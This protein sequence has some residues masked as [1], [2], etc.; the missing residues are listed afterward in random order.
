ML[1]QEH[2]SHL[3]AEAR[4]AYQQGNLARAEDLCRQILAVQRAHPDALNL[5]GAIAQQVGRTDVAIAC[6]RHAVQSDPTNAH[7]HN[8][9]G[10][11][12]THAE[13]LLE[14]VESYRKAIRL[15]PDFAEAHNNLTYALY[16]LGR[17]D[18][19]RASGEQALRLR[20]SFPEANNHL[21]LALM[22]LDR[23]GEAAEQFQTALRLQPRLPAVQR[24]LANAMRALG[25]H[26]DAMYHFQ[27]ALQLDPN[28]AEV[29]CDLGD[30][31]KEQGRFDEAV[32]HFRQALRSK[33]DYALAYWNLSEFA[34]QGLSRLTPEELAQIQSL[35][36]SDRLP[37]LS[38]SVLH[39]TLGN[40]F[41]KQ[42]PWDQA[43]PHFRQGNA[44]RKQLLEQMGQGFDVA[45]HRT[46]IDRTIATF[47]EEFFRQEPPGGSDSEL[48]VFVV[49]MPRS[50]TSLVEQILASHSKAAGAGELWDLPN[51]VANLQRQNKRGVEYPASLGSMK[52]AELGKLAAP[53][54][55][56]L[57]RTDDK[58][59]RVVDKMPQNFLHL[60]LIA[61]LF[62]KAR[63][64]HC[65]R[66]PFDVC[67]SCYFQ[68]FH[69]VNFAWSLED[70]GQYHAEYERLMAHWQ[71]VL[72]L[73]MME[74]RYED[75]VTRQEEVT[76]ELVSF[77]GLEWEDSCLS[78]HKNS[79]PVQ[80]A[81]ALQVR[82]PMYS[83]SIGR[84]QKYRSH[85]EPLRQA[86]GL[87]SLSYPGPGD[88]S[89]HVAYA[90]SQNRD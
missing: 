86:L 31:L 13:Q 75:L 18:E 28:F 59:I 56:R 47:T 55:Q 65:R 57:A 68:N 78:F 88:H 81:S 53:Y 70:L 35:L 22:E 54:L 21:G 48:P 36:S 2:S 49:G 26:A 17:M 50:G 69:R 24:N 29:H 44:L 60:G 58:A 83:S 4:Q 79:R 33:P 84:W 38:K 1:N 5:M 37:L 62:P 15:R 87:G 23:A 11:Y 20:P 12:C 3:L 42:G 39:M 10:V 67:L 63:V 64:I 8:N 16:G 25:R 41:D 80:T 72:P 82:R 61:L 27:Q 43:F 30:F 34:N 51:L 74:V 71:G 85:L 19:A 77:C 14:A 7:Y 6:L 46:A 66:D 89:K 40:V 45:A 73:R 32:T 90:G 9:L 52:A 76:R